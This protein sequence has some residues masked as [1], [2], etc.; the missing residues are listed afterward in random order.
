MD[1]LNRYLDLVE[2]FFRIS[3]E[4]WGRVVSCHVYTCTSMGQVLHAY[5]YTCR[6]EFSGTSLQMVFGKLH[7]E[8]ESKLSKAKTKFFLRKWMSEALELI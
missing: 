4:G 8:S 7:E 2:D 5:T 6:G 1:D 3:P